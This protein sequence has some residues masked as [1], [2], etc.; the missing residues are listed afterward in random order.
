MTWLYPA[1]CTPLSI[2]AQAAGLGTCANWLF[3]FMVVMITPVAFASINNY[4]Y[5]IFAV[6]NFLMAPA[7]FLIFPETAGRSLEEMDEIFAKSNPW[8]PYDVVR[9][10]KKYPHRYDRHGAALEVDP[11]NELKAQEVAK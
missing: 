3:N 1:E 8:N 9:K 7:S 2:R 6:I 4:T 11:L 5:L 10:E